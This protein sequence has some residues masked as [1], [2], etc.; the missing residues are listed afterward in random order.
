MIPKSSTGVNLKDPEKNQY[1]DLLYSHPL[2]LKTE[3]EVWTHYRDRKSIVDLGCGNG[4]FL[5]AYLNQHPEFT[6]LGIDRRFKRLFKTAEKLR[7]TESRVFYGDVPQ[8]VKQSPAFFWDEVWMMFPDPWPKKRHAKHRMIDFRFFFHIFRM[9][10]EGG[11]FCFISDYAP[12][13]E[14]FINSNSRSRL[15]SVSRTLEGDL[16]QDLPGS[17]FKT[18]FQNLERPIYSLEFR[19]IGAKSIRI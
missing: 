17:L 6:G 2:L 18:R 8:F 7:N 4:H 3:E 14:F 11:R 16:F 13:W 5:E 12:Y 15:F 9:L 19:K 1:V 10:K